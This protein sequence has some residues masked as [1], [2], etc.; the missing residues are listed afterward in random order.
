M[1]LIKTEDAVGHV[2]CHD[3]TQIVKGV[4]KDAVFRKGHIVTK[5]DIPVLLSVGKD[6]LYVWEKEEGMLHENDAAQILY[7]MCAGDHMRPSEVKEGKIELIAQCDGLLKVDSK[8]LKAVNSLGEMMIAARHGNFAVKA[9]DKLAGT[10]IIPL[11]IEK[12]K[13][14]RAKQAAGNM[15]LMRLLPFVHKKV[16]IV[17]TGNE[18]FYGRIEDSFT[19]VLREKLAEFDAE[20]MGHVVLGDDHEKITQAILTLIEDG[21]DMVLCS[22]GMS[23]DPDDRTPLAIKNTGADII[24]YGAPVL[25]GAMFLLAYYKGNVPI[26]GLPG[27]VMYSQRTVFDLV[28]PRIMANDPVTA[29]DLA[30]LGEGGL[31][32]SCPVCN[33]PNCGFGKGV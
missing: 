12:E 18:V 24:S 16:G 14:D 20:V 13:M 1:K 33:F 10:R 19:P 21:A 26:M 23:V 7:E 9:G 30:S 3:I 32:L 29:E 27:C 25:P 6:N 8:R 5:E 4:T 15:P 17:T 22:G 11:V 31:C 28:L 2:L